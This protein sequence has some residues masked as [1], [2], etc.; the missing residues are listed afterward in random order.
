FQKKCL[1]KM[2]DVARAGR[3]VLFVSHNMSAILSL[4]TTGYLLDQGEIACRGAIQ[5]VVE[6]YIQT[7]T[8]V[9][10]VPLAERTDRK[11]TGRVRLKSLTIE[12]SGGSAA[13]R[14]GDALRIKIDYAAD[15]KLA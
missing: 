3:T 4:C 15:Q 10:N 6:K 2:E 1:G 7:T 8:A 13:I 9:A 14:C 5:E 12:S 11:G